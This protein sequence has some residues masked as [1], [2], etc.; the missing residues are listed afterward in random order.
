MIARMLNLSCQR[1]RHFAARM[2]HDDRGV[3][4]VEFGLIAP[5]LLVMLIGVIEVSRA[6]AI[7]RRF[8][9]VTS[10]VADLVAR[11]ENLSAA[12]VEGI[13]G[14]AEHTMGVWGTTPLK[15][16]IVPVK[17]SPS[18][19]STRRVYAR[20]TNRPGFGGA[21]PRAYCAN[22]G[23][24][25]PTMLAA[26]ASVI[27]VEATYAFAP[28]LLNSIVPQQQWTDKAILAPRNSCVDF[29]NDNCV[30]TCF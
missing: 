7:D 27:V 13:Y 1:A 6:I 25:A 26:G 3:A 24:L 19:A 17:A 22:Y 18:S 16:E 29:D 11:E 2:R 23:G 15:M 12:S 5:V 14:I 4:A 9:Q 28:L 8:G 30:S 21:T 10:M 20:T